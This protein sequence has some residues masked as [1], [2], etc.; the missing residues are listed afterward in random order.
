M[1]VQENNQTYKN[2]KQHCSTCNSQTTTSF[3]H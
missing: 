2:E 1:N 3:Y